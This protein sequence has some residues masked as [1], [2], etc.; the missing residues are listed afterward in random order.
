LAIG[1]GQL[2]D[3]VHLP[4]IMDALRR[5]PLLGGLATRGRGW[6]LGPP[7]PALEGSDAGDGE[8]GVQ[9]RQTDA[10]EAGTPGG[11]GLTQEQGLLD[12]VIR[13]GLARV[14][15]PVLRRTGFA[16]VAAELLQQVLHGARGKVEAT[17]D[18]AGIEP[19]SVQGSNALA[20]GQGNGSRHEQ[21]S[22]ERQQRYLRE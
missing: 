12:E 20:H 22:S 19:R 16:V 7:P 1:Q 13:R 4:D 11:V 2:F 21:T 10:D 14:D 18:S 9:Q 3:R 8:A 6:L 5:L 17:R 15:R